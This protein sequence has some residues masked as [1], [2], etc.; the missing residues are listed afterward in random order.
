MKA[1]N[2]FRI[3]SIL[4]GIVGLTLII[5]I[6]TALVLGENNMIL[7]FLI[8]MVVSLVLVPAINIPFRK[9]KI[10]LS[11]RSSFVVVAGAWVF[12]SL[13]GAIPL[14]LSG[15]F[16]SFTDCVFESFSGFSTT[17]ATICNDVE[18]LPRSINL[19]R[20][21]THW[22]GGMGIVTLT[23]ALLPLLGVGGFQLI[24]AETTGPEKGKVTAKITT[25]AKAMWII[26]SAFTVVELVLL[27]ICGMDFV[28]ALS[29]A[30][31]TMGTG[32]FST[33][34]ASI[35]GFNSVAIETVITVFMFMAGIN[36]SLF[37]YIFRGNFKEV[38]ENS[39]LKVYIWINVIV[40]L[41]ISLF[42]LPD[43]HN[44][45]TSFRYS[46]FQTVSLL[47][48]T[49]FATADFETWPYAA[50]FFCFLLFFIG[51]CS[52]ST[53]GGVKVVRW[54]V[55]SKQV[56]N[57]VKRMLHPHGIFN[58]RLNNNVGRK[59]VVF[60]IAAF[61]SVY[62]ILILITVFAGTLAGLDLFS[63]LGG[64]LSTVGNVGPGFNA[65]GPSHTMAELPVFLKW[66]YCFT[67]C[68]G[69]LELYT[70]LIFFM[71]AYWRK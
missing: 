17:G 5:P 43:Y 29:H 19:W 71:P 57:E 12:A 10:N 58:I 21:Q 48:T 59:D 45:W 65:L 52:G 14:V 46:S 56:G 1:V 30:F 23:V 62:I 26:Y 61:I 31:A 63:A 2:F 49:G 69:R 64:A 20:C 42:T 54:V 34:N 16:A 36:F 22:L 70:M 68:A 39:E 51:G 66:W 41:A 35:A 50:Q 33:K 25:T 15:T 7:P 67:M 24:K 13:F 53:A 4:L 3:I 60:N 32:G 37:Y 8:P 27:K 55:L 9:Q 18:A 40:I 38:R 28:D 6:V 44:F 11:I 47:T